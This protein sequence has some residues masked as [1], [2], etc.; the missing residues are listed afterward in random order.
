MN[1][2]SVKPHSLWRAVDTVPGDNTI[3]TAE[4]DLTQNSFV[5]DALKSANVSGV[6]STTEP[7]ALVSDAAGLSINDTSD[8][9]I[10]ATESTSVAFTVAGLANDVTG[11]VTFTDSSNQ[12]VVVN[13]QGSGNYS[14]DLSTL[15]DGTITSSLSAADAAGHATMST[16]NTVSLD[17]DRDLNPTVSISAANPSHVTFTISGL[18]GDEAGTIT[19]TD[20]KNQQDV[21]PVGSNGNYVADLSNLANGTVTYLLSVTDPAGNVT[22][23]DP[24]I[25]LGDGSANAPSGVAQLPSLLDGYASRP[26]WNV[27]GVDYAVGVQAGTVLKIPSAANLPNGA[28]LHPGAIYIDGNNVTLNGYNL[29][30]LTVMIN[31]DATGTVTISNCASTTSGIIRSTVDARA[32]LVVENCTLD[33]GG[34]ASD[35]DF[36]TIMTW[37]PTTVEYCFIGNSAQGIHVSGADFTAQYNVLEGFSWEKDNHANA[38]YVSGSNDPTVSTTIA[39]NTIYSEVTSGPPN[40]PIGIGAAIA[41]FDDGGNFYN[42]QVSNNTVISASPGAASYLIGYYVYGQHSATGGTVSNNYLASVNGWNGGNSGAFGAFYGGSTGVVQATYTNNV[43]LAN[44][45]TITG[46]NTEVAGPTSSDPSITSFSTDSGTVGDHT[47]NDNTLTVTGTAAANSAVKVFDGANQIGTATANS[48]GVWTYTTAALTDGLHNLT[49][50][51]NA[52]AVSAA[53]SVTIDTAAPATPNIVSNSI[54]ANK[55]TLNGTA[56]ANSNVQVFDGATQLGTATTN[57]SG[58]WT[59]TTATLTTGTHNFTDQSHGC[60]RQ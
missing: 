51:N 24:P 26:S 33:G 11:A 9:V 35:R 13:I 57:S 3:A 43:D 32:N 59:F 42:S 37:C 60:R 41:F 45:K 46:S 2:L 27:A 31:S 20:A 14:A 44:G 52:G 30:G 16:G 39:Y 19:F 21:V 10:N 5:S 8:H 48:S 7:A 4:T 15:S 12:H 34:P 18:E 17:A 1:K 50:K 47:T 22:T 29:T 25:N 55:V 40:G 54:S 56:E 53:L 36:A 49:A 38:I 23:V 6:V 28:S 58:A